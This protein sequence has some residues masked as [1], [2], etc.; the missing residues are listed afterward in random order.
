MQ[1]RAQNA[2]HKNLPPK[3]CCCRVALFLATIPDVLLQYQNM[4]AVDE[5]YFHCCDSDKI[6]LLL[7][8]EGKKG[9]NHHPTKTINQSI[10]PMSK[11]VH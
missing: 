2:M 6:L 10:H 4:V 11:E 9:T 1:C 8:K 5:S 3:P 7:L